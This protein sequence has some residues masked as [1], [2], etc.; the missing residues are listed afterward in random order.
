MKRNKPFPCIANGR[1]EA[2]QEKKNSENITTHT[3]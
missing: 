2:Q 3:A 1:G